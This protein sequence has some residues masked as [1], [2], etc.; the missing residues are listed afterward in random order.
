MNVLL[1]LLYRRKFHGLIETTKSA[2]VLLTESYT[3]MVHLSATRVCVC[4]CVCVCVFMSMCPPQ[5]H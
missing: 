2:I 4:V 1:G 5:G 3:C